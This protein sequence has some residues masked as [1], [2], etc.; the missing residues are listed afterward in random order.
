MLWSNPL[1]NL[2][3]NLGLKA[4]NALNRPHTQ[5][6]L[7]IK[8]LN[9]EVEV[10]RD[11]W[12]TP[13]IFGRSI[14]DVVF[15]QG[16]VHAQE[17]LWQMDLCR[18]L[19]A[20]RLSEILGKPTLST[21]IAMRTMG[22]RKWAEKSTSNVEGQERTILGAY[23]DGV[24]A[25]IRREPLPLEFR[26]LR[27]S[28]EPWT[29]ADTLSWNYL[30]F[31]NLGTSWESEL[32]RGQLI[33]AIGPEKASELELAIEEAGPLILDASWPSPLQS[34]NRYA[35]PSRKDGVGSNNWAISSQRSKSAAPLLA[36]DMHVGLTNPAIFFQNHL[37]CAALDVVGVSFP[38][39]PLVVQG[40][41]GR[42][43]WGFTNGFADVQDL[44]V[45][46]LRTQ[47]GR[48][49]YELRG[50]WQPVVYRQ[51]KILVKGQP[52]HTETVAETAHGPIINH[53]L[54]SSVTPELPPLAM[55]WTAFETYTSFKAVI[56]MNQAQDCQEFRQAL[57]EWVS[58]VQ[59][60]V[61]ADTQ[62]NIAFLQAGEIPIRAH[63]DGS[64]PMPGWT[65][66]REWVGRIPFDELPQLHNPPRGF[67]VTANNR[68]AGSDYPYYL[69]RDYINAD[70]AQRITELIEGTPA[71]DLE[72]I[73]K[74]QLD[75][76]PP[77][78]RKMIQLSRDLHADDPELAEALQM[79]ARWDGNLD[80]GSVPA[81]I[82]EVWV[83]QILAL[84]LD[85]KLSGLEARV[86]GSYPAGLWGL[87]SW[88]W[89]SARLEDPGSHWWDHDGL[90][91]RNGVLLEALQRSLAYLRQKL[92]PDVRS[93]RWGSLHQLTFSHVL[94]QARPLDKIF[95]RGPYPIGGDSGTV[96]SAYTSWYENDPEGAIGPP[97]RFLI[98]MADPAHAQVTFA[99]GQ[100]GRPGTPH[101]DDGIEDWFS[102]QYH[103][104]LFLREE[105]E[106]YT[107]S[108]LI[109][110]PG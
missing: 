76:R 61:F 32:L 17:R 110:E 79:I 77:S 106:R 83:R 56:R 2:L 58:P 36:N 8:G 22:F 37:S 42:V 103:L 75:Q 34:G 107:E 108:R 86:R 93:W 48:L 1:L 70:R 81:A 98:D 82:V 31:L 89:L 60:V 74:I 54:L 18:R 90:S 16:F 9:G 26:L 10:I 30:L 19:G 4:F 71:H 69:G 80:A 94:G 87:H 25:C 68:V 57:R 29:L 65:G 55:R 109:L 21:D 52:A 102:G 20:G 53:A 35:G 97:F 43:A 46:H 96:S 100:S 101:Y 62:N 44:Y 78:T 15:A 24:N 11:V 28:P 7:S 13:H 63:G 73:K 38:G 95:N 72:S 84:V 67:I 64:K 92:G 45:E 99:P 27:Y 88:E 85:G 50:E 3:A 105:I 47:D 91:G 104:L 14:E 51:E 66:E 12:G 6:R 49:E 40:H 5:A 23:C 39:I 59:N 33:S 41:N